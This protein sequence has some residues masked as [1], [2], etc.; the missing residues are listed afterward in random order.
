MYCM[1][2]NSLTVRIVDIMGSDRGW[3]S[4]EGVRVG[5][6]I[7]ATA[8]SH[9]EVPVL[10][11]SLDGVRQTDTS[12]ARE[13]VI[14]VAKDLRPHR[15]FCLI[16]VAH[17]DIVSNW[18]VVASRMEQPLLLW[19]DKQWRLL[20]NQPSEGLRAMFEH[21]MAVRSTATAEAAAHLKL[22]VPNASNK[23]KELWKGGY[24]LRRERVA[25]SGGIEH[26]YFAIG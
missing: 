7:R 25:A 22:G 11:I 3:G 16:D 14:R 8:A 2:G 4:D 23:L 13:S 19:A 9:P 20:G 10:S 12:F 17:E 26:E 6:A 1:K 24:V 5:I 21:V 18:D 15:G